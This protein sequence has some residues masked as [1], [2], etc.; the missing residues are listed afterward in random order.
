MTHLIRFEDLQ[1]IFHY[2][3]AHLPD[4]RQPSPNTRYTIQDA[5]LVVH[6]ISLCCFWEHSDA[7]LPTRPMPALPTPDKGM[8]MGVPV[9]RGGR[10]GL[11]H[12]LPRFKAAAF[13]R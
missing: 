6:P 12:L 13:E 10:N 1:A 3:I 4:H 11:T 7:G 5:A 2:S 8:P 9:R